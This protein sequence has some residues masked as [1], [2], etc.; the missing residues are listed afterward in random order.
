MAGYKWLL[1]EKEIEK[2]NCSMGQSKL[3]EQ[4]ENFLII[5][6]GPEIGVKSK[7][8]RIRYEKNILENVKMVLNLL[9]VKP[10]RINHVLG[11]IYVEV[12]DAPRVAGELVKVFGISSISPSWKIP[13]KLDFF[14]KKASEIVVERL[15]PN[16]TFKVECN[17]V[18]EHSFT[19]LDVSRKLGEKILGLR[20]DVKVN[21][22]RP[23]SVVGVEIRNDNGFLFL[24][25]FQGAGG[26]PF[27]CQ[28]RIVCLLSDG[29]DSP[30]A[31]WLVMRRGCVPV[32]VFFDLQPFSDKFLQHKALKNAET[33]A[34][35]A[36]G[37]KL[38]FYIVPHGENLKYFAENAPK[39]LTCILCK[40]TMY[41]IAELIAD[42][43]KALG[44]VTGESIGEQASQTLWNLKV[45]SEAVNKYPVHRP[46]LGFDKTDTEEIARK[47]GTYEISKLKAKGCSAVP[48]KPSL[49]A[50]L[51]KVVE[52]ERN[53]KIKDLTARSLKKAEKRILPKN[54]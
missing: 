1:K 3:T 45:L 16:S 26:F 42:K 20:S 5:R 33:L 36:P 25:T 23:D 29:L 22:D 46:L 9:N 47:I 39:N 50:D 32:F 7:R 19:S 40:R 41:R 18:G 51:K 49:K 2:L 44:I 6:F 30:V 10:K 53:L 31:S 8:T 24:K 48:P 12:D 4:K 52:I 43:E 21:L 28:G 37:T 27:G 35:W 38:V 15:P 13:S 11:R 34:K 54:K 14:V 17:R